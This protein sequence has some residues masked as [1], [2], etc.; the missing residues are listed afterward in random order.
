[1]TQEVF[2][3][4]KT[5]MKK[6]NVKCFYKKLIV[7]KNYPALENNKKARRELYVLSM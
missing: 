5:P 6:I 3:G 7:K 1:M 4:V 2:C